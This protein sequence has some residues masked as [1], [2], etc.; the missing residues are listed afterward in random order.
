MSVLF[1]EMQLVEITT[2]SAPPRVYDFIYSQYK[3][4]LKEATVGVPVELHEPIKKAV[5]N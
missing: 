2:L 5:T 4:A 3:T 1:D